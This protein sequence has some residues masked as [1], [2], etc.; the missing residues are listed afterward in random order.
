MDRDALSTPAPWTSVS[1]AY[2]RTI[3]PIFERYAGALLDLVGVDPT[4]RVLDVACGPGTTTLLAAARAS[5]VSA[6]D[7]SPGMLEQLRLRVR[8]SASKIAVDAELMDAQRLTFHD[9]TFDAV[10]CSFGLMFVPDRARALEE[11]RRVLRPGGKIG[12][13]TWASRDKRPLMALAFDAARDAVGAPI[14]PPGPMQT[15]EECESELGAAGFRDV[16]AREHEDFA[17]FASVDDYWN[18]RLSAGAPIAVMRSSMTREAW[19]SIE[20]RILEAIRARVGEGGL[21]LGAQ[22]ILTVASR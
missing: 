12:L 19:D 5:R 9:G 13:A 22:A 18:A 7:F 20:R 14:P 16:V 11:M 10:V 15:I 4:M 21:R 17:E 2:A 8:G 3:T 6:I 1:E